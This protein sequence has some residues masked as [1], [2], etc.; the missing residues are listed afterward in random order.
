MLESINNHHKL[1]IN[2]ILSVII[3][4]KKCLSDYLDGVFIQI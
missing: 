3:H 2:R 4:Q 1:S